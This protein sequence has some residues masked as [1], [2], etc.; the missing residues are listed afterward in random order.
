M[1]SGVPLCESDR[2][3]RQQKTPMEEALCK[4]AV[5]RVFVIQ[6]GQQFGVSLIV[7]QLDFPI[8]QFRPGTKGYVYLISGVLES[9]MHHH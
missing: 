6:K 3:Y 5:H 7:D 4:R 1:L 8:A 9:Q 2:T